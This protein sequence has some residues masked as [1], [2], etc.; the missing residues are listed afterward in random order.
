MVAVSV[1]GSLRR[2]RRARSGALFATFGLALTLAACG[3]SGQQAQQKP[4]AQ[5]ASQ[6]ANPRA[7]DSTGLL[8][9][10]PLGDR[11][12]GKADAPVTI[13]EYASL[14]CSHCANFHERT[15][16]AFKEKYIDT[17]KVR[18]VFREFPLDPLSTAASMIARCAPEPRYFPIVTV[19][20]QQ[21]RAWAGSEKPLEELLAIARQAGFSQESFDACLKNQSVYDGLNEVKKRGS[22][23]FGVNST[24]TFF[25]N[26]EIR[27]GDL[28][29][30]ELESLIAPHL[31]N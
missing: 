22:E 8:Q 12:L 28:S 10:G 13:V 21:Q 16:P 20:F 29:L 30:A 24:P 18:L 6:T 27:R 26:G 1:A 4:P 14:T 19:L 23:V 2:A 31:K 7:V 17:G 11:I 9:P 25:I 15:Y 5:Q 3:D